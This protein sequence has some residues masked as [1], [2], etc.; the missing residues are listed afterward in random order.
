VLTA[1]VAGGVVELDSA[2]PETF[3]ARLIGVTLLVGFVYETALIALRGQTLGKMAVRIRVVR[4]DDGAL[5]GWGPSLIR[6]F[7]PVAASIVPLGA[8]VVYLWMLWD[9]RRQG[10]HDRA[11]RTLVVGARPSV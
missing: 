3:P 1:L 10:L 5:P 2:S 7:V 9:P 11:A 8:L 4:Q 6:W